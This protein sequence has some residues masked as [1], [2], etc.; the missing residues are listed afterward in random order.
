M[1]NVYIAT[2]IPFGYWAAE[3]YVEIWR[4]NLACK[5]PGMNRD[6]VAWMRCGYWAVEGYVEIFG[7][8]ETEPLT[9]VLA[10]VTRYARKGALI[11][12]AR[13][14]LFPGTALKNRCVPSVGKELVAIDVHHEQLHIAE[15]GSCVQKQVFEGWV[16]DP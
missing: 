13:R 15:V 11:V 10:S 4:G 6:I 9:F 1:K 12:N 8:S 7:T 2:Y 3:G 5:I 16:V 14:F